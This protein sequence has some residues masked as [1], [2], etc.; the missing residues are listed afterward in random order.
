MVRLSIDESRADVTNRGGAGTLS[1]IFLDEQQ[2]PVVIPGGSRT[3]G[4]AVS[5]DN[6]EVWVANQGNGTIT[7]VDTD[8]LQVK[9]TIAVAPTNRLEFL[10]DGRVVVP[11][12]NSS[13]GSQRYVRFYNAGTLQPERTLTFAGEN[14]GTGIRVLAANRLL[15]VSDSALNALFIVDPDSDT[16]PELLLSSP[17]NPDGLAWS[18]LRVG[19]TVSE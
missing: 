10:P 1:V 2:E 18:P 6:L 5:P 3:E 8:S 17:D 9:S 14:A 4:I 7:I 13:D 11:G 16:P 12:G 15:F 19:Q